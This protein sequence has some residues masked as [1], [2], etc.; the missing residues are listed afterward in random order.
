MTATIQ[1]HNERPAKVWSSGGAAYDEI[2]RQIAS[3]LD[4]CVRRLAPQP[5]ERILDLA[6]GTGWTARLIARH[7]AQVTG[8]DIAADLI[9][10]AE[11]QAGGPEYEVGDAEALHFDDSAFDGISST[12]GVMFAS[13]PEAVAGEL[14]R[15]CRPGGRIALVVWKD[16]SNLAKMFGVMRPY[17]PPPPDPAPPSPFAWGNRAR[18]TELLGEAFDLTFEEGVTVYHDRDGRAAWEVFLTGYGPTKM[19]ASALDP[20]HRAALEADFIAFHDGFKAP[21]GISMPREY[22]LIHGRRT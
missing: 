8:V 15:V 10:A 4:H 6:T 18:A 3:A 14:A 17:M 20:V 2:S 11:A 9:A 22:L 13:R 12:F 16:D 7:G 21:L 1:P 5:G 19:L